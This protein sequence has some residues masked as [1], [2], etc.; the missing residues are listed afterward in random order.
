M[1]AIQEAV[2]LDTKAWILVAEL[3]VELAIKRACEDVCAMQLSGR[4]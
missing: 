4:P 3:D 1:A 2:S